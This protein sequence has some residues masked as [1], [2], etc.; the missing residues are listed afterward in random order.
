MRRKS[1]GYNLQIKKYSSSW[2][3]IQEKEKRLKTFVLFE[4]YEPVTYG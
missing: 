4:N 1:R 2:V 3:K